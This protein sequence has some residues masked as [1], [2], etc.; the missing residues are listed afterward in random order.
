M[1]PKSERADSFKLS[2]TKVAQYRDQ[3]FVIV[4]GLLDPEEVETLKSRARAIVTGES[5]KDLRRLIVRDVRVAKGKVKVDDPEHG[6]W[7]LFDPD[8]FDEYFR[9]YPATSS[10]L[11]VCESLIGPDLMAFLVMMIYKPPM[12]EEAVHHYHQDALY[13]PFGPHD[14]VLG[15]WVALD[16]TDGDN[17]TLRVIPG[18]HKGELHKHEKPEGDVNLG[19]FGV[20]GYDDHPNEVVVELEPGDGIFFH[21]RLLHK[22]GGNRT[23]RHRRVMTV[24]YANARCQWTVPEPPT[25]HFNMRLVRGQRH[26][27]CV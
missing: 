25:T 22:T 16:R 19:I 4:R 17:G 27:N 9:A 18:S 14:G 26:G 23:E 2:S 21:S 15:S 11:D 7:K 12:M 24:H 1:A 3:G 6:M 13:F 5:P 10:I 20:P 8:R